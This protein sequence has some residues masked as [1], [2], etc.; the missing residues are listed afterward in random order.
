MNN[1]PDILEKQIIFVH[2]TSANDKQIKVDNG[3]LSISREG[4]KVQ[5]IPLHKIAVCIFI[6]N[7]TFTSN[8]LEL[9]TSAGGSIIFCK[10]SFATFASFHANASGHYLLRAVQYRASPEQEFVWAKKLMKNKIICQIRA[11]VDIEPSNK[12]ELN[13]MKKRVILAIESAPNSDTLRGIEGTMQKYYFGQIYSDH[14]WLRRIPQAKLDPINVLLDI[15]YSML[16]N[17]TDCFL[18]LYGFDSYKGFY[19]TLFFQRKS[20]ACDVM[21]PF[22]VLIDRTI[23]KMYALGQVDE[24]DFEIYG[25]NYNLP[26]SKSGKYYKLFS[27]ELMNYR[28]PL[29]LY[30]QQLNRHFLKPEK[31]QFPEFNYKPYR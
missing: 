11:L 15:G 10:T 9:I 25:P 26:W 2:S 29:Y 24:K 13:L 18:Q 23:R 8:I 12:I 22:R 30:C 16:F 17:L 14:G 5:K 28:E 1:L 19:H 27:E 21:E 20:L 6:G 4:K 31:Y 3:N 7:G